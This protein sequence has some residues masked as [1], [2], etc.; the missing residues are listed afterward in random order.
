MRST[1]AEGKAVSR[2]IPTH[3]VTA[4]EYRAGFLSFTVTTRLEKGTHDPV[5]ADPFAPMSG[6]IVPAKRAATLQSDD[7]RTVT[8]RRGALA[9][10]TAKLAVPVNGLPHLWAFHD[11]LMVTIGGDLTAK[12]LLAVAESLAPLGK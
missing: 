5:L 11:G 2:Q 1:R 9:G 12:R 3:D 7:V 4:L 8:L 6:W 10:E